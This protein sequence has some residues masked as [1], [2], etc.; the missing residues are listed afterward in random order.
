MPRIVVM[1]MVRGD[2]HPERGTQF[3]SKRRTAR[4]HEA[5]GHISTQQ[6]SHQ[7]QASEYIASSEM[8]LRWPH[9]PL[10]STMPQCG[11]ACQWDNPVAC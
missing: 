4:R 10:H 6:Q 11:I 5:D 3:Q 7:Q 1:Q 9:N 8:Q 2:G